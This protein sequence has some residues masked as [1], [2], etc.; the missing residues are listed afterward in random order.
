M[1]PGLLG[2]RSAMKGTAMGVRIRY[3]DRVL[4]SVAVL[5]I[6]S[7]S[8][9]P[10]YA[11]AACPRLSDEEYD[12]RADVVFVGTAL[13]GGSA[14]PSGQD[15]TTRFV[16][17]EVRKGEI[18]AEVEVITAS[19][20]SG[21][22]PEAEFRPRSGSGWLIYGYK[23]TDRPGVYATNLCVGT[24]SL[25][26]STEVATGRPRTS[27]PSPSPGPNGPP[28]SSQTSAAASPGGADRPQGNRTGKLVT[29]GGALA[30]VAVGLGAHKRGKQRRQ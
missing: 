16:V 25:N 27:A 29:A 23:V 17:E 14:T 8:T 22:L 4:L 20:T 28:T 26:V 21:P 3:V 1:A 10:A 15:A 7:A 9:V 11:Q 2:V 13:A 30:A 24:T 6:A 12:A 5:L 18:A 19:G